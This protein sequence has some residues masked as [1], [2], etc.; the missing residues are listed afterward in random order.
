MDA[1]KIINI[2]CHKNMLESQIIVHSFEQISR[3]QISARL[4]TLS[5]PACHEDFLF[6]WRPYFTTLS[7]TQKEISFDQPLLIPLSQ[8]WIIRIDS[9]NSYYITLGPLAEITA[10]LFFQYPSYVNLPTVVLYCIYLAQ[11]YE[12]IIL[13]L[14]LKIHIGNFSVKVIS[15]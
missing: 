11:T 4:K 8:F 14:K 7:I 1:V 3:G 6:D 9:M 15:T 13:T 10:S 5:K 12:E 2:F